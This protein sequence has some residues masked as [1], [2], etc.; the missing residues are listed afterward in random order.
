MKKLPVLIVAQAGFEPVYSHPGDAGADLR[1]RVE[2]V[3]PAGQ[4]Q[5]LPTGVSV[6]IPNGFVGLVHSRS[7]MAAKHGV[8]VLNSPGTVD[9]GYRGEI[10]VTL[11]N[12][13]DQDFK[14]A[15]GERIAQLLFQ[16]IEIADFIAV[17]LLPESHRGGN[18][19]GSTGSR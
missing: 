17:E 4:R 9:A 14:V 7:G 15:A 19:F 6:A 1:S 18:G 8:F 5:T 11:Q 13:S 10:S 12:T 3:I 2:T 16:Q